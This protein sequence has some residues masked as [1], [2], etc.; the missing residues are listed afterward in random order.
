MAEEKKRSG[1]MVIL[2][3]V[4]L[5][6]GISMVGTFIIVKYLNA[7]PA[8]QK[9]TSQLSR[10]MA[11]LIRSGS[12]QTFPLRGGNQVLVVDSLT[13]LVGSAQCSQEIGIDTPQIMDGIQ[14]LIL[15]KS[16]NEILNPDGFQTLKQQIADLV[17]QI[18]GYTG[19]KA[20]L[21]V[22]Q[23]YMYIKAVAST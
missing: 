1:L 6:A 8:Q 17:D 12:N 5:S 9:V 21:G 10:T 18:T 11:I 13:F 16:A 20:P 2:I 15:S 22:L 23:V 19:D 4:I 3:A 14:M 7:P